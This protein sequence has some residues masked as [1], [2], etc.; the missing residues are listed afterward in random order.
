MGMSK[1]GEQGNADCQPYAMQVKFFFF[2][3]LG[4]NLGV[5]GGEEATKT[6]LLEGFYHPQSH[7]T[8]GRRGPHY[9]RLPFS[10]THIHTHFSRS[11]FPAS[12]C[13]DV[14]P[15]A[16]RRDGEQGQDTCR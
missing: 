8:R 6:E 11:M 7:K 14:F 4:N 16:R 1:R 15:S 3:I 5:P 12:V 2:F 9:A 10:L 13:A